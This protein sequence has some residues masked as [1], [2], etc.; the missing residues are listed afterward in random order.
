MRRYRY[1]LISALAALLISALVDASG[2]I[3]PLDTPAVLTNRAES[4]FMLSVARAGSRL[5]AVGEFGRIIVSNDHGKTWKQVVSPVSA[6]LVSVCFST[7]KTGWATGHGGV[8]LHTTDGG[9]TWEKVIDGRQVVTLALDYYQQRLAAGDAAAA[10]YI[11]DVQ[12]NFK[13]GPEMPFL[14]VWFGDKGHGFVVGGFGL[15][16]AT[17]DGGKHWTPWMDRVQNPDVLHL[18]AVSRV[19]DDVFIVGE[20][21]MVWKLDESGQ[22]FNAQPSGYTGSF[23]GV[24]GDKNNVIAFGLRGNAY[25]SRDE[26]KS[27]QSLSLPTQASINDGVVTP[28]GILALVTQSGELVAGLVN[29]SEFIV[30]R[31]KHP[32]VLAGVVFTEP[33]TLVIAGM[34]GVQSEA[35]SITPRSTAQAFK[36]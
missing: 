36:K 3:D 11:Q 13:N 32:T 34:N 31:V 18:N 16:L 35:L 2:F 4:S 25:R 29:S 21:G 8:V 30:S 1:K 15:I 23:F 22:H 6:D 33:N 19:G 12:L 5:I 24:T 7:D 14:D 28:E 26:G 10:Q 9:L 27:W 20:R 17:Q